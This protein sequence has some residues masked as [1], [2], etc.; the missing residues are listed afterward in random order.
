MFGLRVS[1]KP[2][3]T[4][5]TRQVGSEPQT[6][7]PQTH[8]DK[9]TTTNTK[10]QHTTTTHNHNTQAQTHNH[11][12]TTTNTAHKHNTQTQ[13]QTH[14]YIQQYNYLCVC[15]FCILPG[16]WSQGSTFGCQLE[17]LATP[18]RELP[19]T[20]ITIPNPRTHKQSQ[21][22]QNSQPWQHVHHRGMRTND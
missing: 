17:T 22:P 8:N 18:R 7:K 19:N 11:K 10:P 9:H 4:E 5:A 3:E 1:P 21:K 2:T 20:K 16:M 15:V 13:P 6:Q 12:H 14:I